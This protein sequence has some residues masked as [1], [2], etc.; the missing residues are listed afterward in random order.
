VLGEASLLAF[1]CIKANARRND[2]GE[3]PERGVSDCICI[4]SMAPYIVHSEERSADGG[5]PDQK[6]CGKKFCEQIE[7]LVHADA[8]NS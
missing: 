2:R 5:Q 7:K 4:V 3:V 6:G 1:D 8:R